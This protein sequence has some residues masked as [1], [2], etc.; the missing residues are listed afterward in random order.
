[1]VYSVAVH[2]WPGMNWCREIDK[3][4][5]LLTF[6]AILGD[7]RHQS[8]WIHWIHWSLQSIEL[9]IIFPWFPMCHSG[10]ILGDKAIPS[11]KRQKMLPWSLLWLDF[12]NWPL[13]SIFHPCFIHFSS[14]FHP[15]VIH[16]SSIC[17]RFLLCQSTR[18]SG[19]TQ[20]VTLR[21]Q[22]PGD[23][24]IEIWGPELCFLRMVFLVTQSW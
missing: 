11:W 8:A 5:N 1:M 6:S 20:W 12:K 13:S 10:P 17:H 19:L 7:S 18:C 15:F 4:S 21:R 2:P 14:I 23:V 24:Q 22:L 16:L 9:V 3:V